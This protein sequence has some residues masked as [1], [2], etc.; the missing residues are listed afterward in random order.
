[1][2]IKVSCLIDLYCEPTQ[3]CLKDLTTKPFLIDLP[4]FYT[5]GNAIWGQTNL[6]SLWLIFSILLVTCTIL[7]DCKIRY[8]KTFS[9]TL[10]SNVNTGWS[11][12]CFT[13]LVVN[14]VV[15]INMHTFTK[16]SPSPN[17]QITFF[18]IL[19]FFFLYSFCWSGSAKV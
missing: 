9:G 6:E 5:C 4:N 17:L 13:N 7:T 19:F 18:K 2:L 8:D 16:L 3:R 15:T 11:K 12:P 14:V 1:M 10:V